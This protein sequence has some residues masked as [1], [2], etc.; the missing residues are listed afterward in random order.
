M[1]ILGF[2]IILHNLV[3]AIAIYGR[4]ESCPGWKLNKLPDVKKFLRESG[5]A[6]SY[7]NLEIKW[8][9]GRIPEL[10]I[11]EDDGKLNEKIDLAPLTTEG[12]HQILRNRGFEKK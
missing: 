1:N 4:I 9:P 8:I 2:L 12:I 6:D 3:F 11:Y 7:Q 10:F 5:N